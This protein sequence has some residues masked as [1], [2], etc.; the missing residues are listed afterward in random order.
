M[1]IPSNGIY[2]IV[3]ILAN[4]N[5]GIYLIVEILANQNNGTYWIAEILE[6]HLTEY[7]G[8]LI[9]WYMVL[10]CIILYYIVLWYYG[11]MVLWYHGI[12]V[13]WYILFFIS[14]LSAGFAASR[15][16]IFRTCIWKIECISIIF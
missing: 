12:M 9:L 4:Q 10:Y 16:F 3:E 13:L 11:I 8:L 15:E 1:D 2:L 6:T 5:N 7:I 14:F